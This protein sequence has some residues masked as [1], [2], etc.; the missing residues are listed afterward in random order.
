MSMDPILIVLGTLFSAILV[1]IAI[2]FFSLR[3]YLSCLLLILLITLGYLWLL[4]KLVP[5]PSSQ[6]SDVGLRQVYPEP[7]PSTS[8]TVH[9]QGRPKDAYVLEC[10]WECSLSCRTDHRPFSIILVH[11]LGA[12][13][14][15]T[16]VDGQVFWIKHLLPEDLRAK[17]LDLRVRSFCFDYESYWL[18]DSNLRL[19]ET[20]T[21]L[22]QALI[23]EE[24]MRP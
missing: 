15:R 5:L 16:W 9:R 18:R 8:H 21:S 14:S 19:R 23:G 13:P 20:A 2:A 17:N 10:L 11:G 22:V 12:N 1:P 7:I 4:Q 3:T 24:V 6:R